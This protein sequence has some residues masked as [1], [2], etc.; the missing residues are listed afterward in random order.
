MIV[1]FRFLT[2]LGLAAF[3]LAASSARACK[4]PVFRYA[5][6]RWT[7]DRYKMV[8]IIDAAINDQTKEALAELQRLSD[9]QANVDVDIVD[10]SK[11]TEEEMWQVDGLDG[12]EE[13]PLLQVFFPERDGRR[14]LCWSG[15]LTPAAIEAWRDSPL[16]RGCLRRP[17]LH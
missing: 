14:K 6:E 9:S 8:A 13:T 7:A 2:L 11:L 4:L 16:R 10:L 1:R 12:S 15:E 17:G 3:C 5:L